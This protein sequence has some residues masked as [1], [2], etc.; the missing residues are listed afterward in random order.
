MD[1][2]VHSLKLLRLKR[3]NEMTKKSPARKSLFDSAVNYLMPTAA[4][5]SHNE[6]SDET[7]VDEE[8]SNN[9]APKRIKGNKKV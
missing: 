7:Q 2:D 9:E 3:K 6:T 4:I 8:C 5:V 1:N